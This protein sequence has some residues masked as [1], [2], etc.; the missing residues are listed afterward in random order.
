M[1][2]GGPLTS[3]NRGNVLSLSSSAGS[4]RIGGL[5]GQRAIELPTPGDKRPLGF[6]G[7]AIGTFPT[8]VGP[9]SRM[10]SFQGS[11]QGVQGLQGHFGMPMGMDIAPPSTLD[12]SEFPSLTNRLGNDSLS[13][14]LTS[15]ANYGSLVGIMKTP[16]SESTEFTMSSEDFPALPGTQTV[17]EN[18]T[19]GQGIN[20]SLFFCIAESKNTASVCA[21]SMG[22]T[23]G[24]KRGLQI[25]SE[26]KVTNIPSN[27]VADQFGMAGLLTF[28]RVAETDSSLV[29]L[30]LGSDLTTL[31][32]NLT[33][34][35]V[36]Y[37]TFGGPW[38]ETPC[39]PQDIDFHGPPEYLTNSFIKEKLPHPKLSRYTEDLLFYLFYTYT[40][41]VLQLAAAT[42]LYNREWRFH[43]DERIWITRLPGAQVFEKTTTYERASYLCFDP[44]HW[45]KATRR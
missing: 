16:T 12:L 10:G 19:S 44:H 34:P 31:G 6:G 4:Q 11:S 15:R 9:A 42:E 7:P 1:G 14:S 37:T 5:I 26:G 24:N 35:D 13:S 38:S 40:G 23:S 28:I 3:P 17:N 8:A 29:S 32:L 45:R 33:S 25:S 2:P 22:L 21:T 20:S 41:D 36:L 27:M 30:A 39:R 18:N 43:K